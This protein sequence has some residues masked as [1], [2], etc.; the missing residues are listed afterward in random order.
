MIKKIKSGLGTLAIALAFAGPANS[1]D[2]EAQAYN[3]QTRGNAPYV[4]INNY[5]AKGMAV[6]GFIAAAGLVCIC[7]REKDI[8]LQD[9]LGI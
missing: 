8:E 6:A 4:S 7:Q 9:D 1:Q 2:V 5:D 3:P